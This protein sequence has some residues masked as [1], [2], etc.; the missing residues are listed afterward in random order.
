MAHE[1]SFDTNGNAEAFFAMKPAWHNLGK[2]LDHAPTSEAAIEA[3]GLD[4]RIQMKP[5]QTTDGTRVKDHFA[6]CRT[7]TGEVMGVVTDKYKVVQNRDAFKFLDSLI[8][9]GDMRYESAGALKG[10][11]V[12]WVLGRL[13]SVDQIAENDV[14]LRYVLFSTSHDGT[15]S[16]H[17][18]PTSTRVVCANTLRIAT[19]ADKGIRHTGDIKDKLRVAR[20]YLS[21]FDEGFTLFRDKAQILAQRRFTPEQSKAYIQAMFPEVKEF[22]RARSIREQKVNRVR[23]NYVNPRQNIASIKGTWWALLNAVTESIDHA[24]A[25]MA[26]RTREAAEA[27]M[28]SVVDGTGADFKAKAFRMAVEMAG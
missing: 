6:T 20:L 2:V 10:G 17:A 22:G 8:E 9:S 14:S 28:L 18:I 25:T 11:R 4:W 19:S 7:D 1:L 21:Q 3:A 13:P 26:K 5:L 23:A 12:V 27:K 16:I 15:A 24:P